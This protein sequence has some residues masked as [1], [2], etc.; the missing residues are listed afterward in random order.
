MV[1]G[2]GGSIGAEMCR[3]IARYKPKHL[4]LL[5]R[6]E[7]ALFEIDRELKKSFPDL[8]CTPYV[9]D[10]NDQVRLREIFK[11]ECPNAIFHAAAHKH[12]PMMELNPGESVKNNILGTKCL[13]DTASEAGVEK[14]VMISTDKAVNPTSVMG[15]TKRI[16]EMYVQQLAGHTKSKTEFVTVRFGNV[17]GSNGSVVPI[18]KE[19]ISNGGPVT[20]T[21]PEMTRYFMTIPEASQLVLQAGTMGKGGEIFLLD[22]G[23]PVKIVDLAVALITLSG[24][25]PDEDIDIRFTGMRPG[26]KLFEEL[27]ITGE[28]VSRTAHPKIGIIK[29]RPE[30]FDHVCAGIQ[31]LTT[32]MDANDEDK[33]RGELQGVVPEYEP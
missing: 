13:A 14:F 5:E 3:Q 4:L 15:C 27:S 11:A 20:V 29:K 21:H 25:R 22:M 32:I 26:E 23:E 12:V 6:M 7:N 10:I 33:I 1:S 30:D 16:A 17:L 28:D 19:Q 2:A 24:L 31:R 18:F 8:V 9:A